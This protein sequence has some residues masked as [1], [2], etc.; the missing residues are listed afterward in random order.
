MS[1][2][3]RLALSLAVT[4]GLSLGLGCATTTATLGGEATGR[5]QFG[6]TEHTDSFSARSTAGC[7]RNN[8]CGDGFICCF[9]TGDPGGKPTRVGFCSSREMCDTVTPPAP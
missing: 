3:Q 7:T 8:Q 4:L 2:P 6:E 5:A 9:S 1:N